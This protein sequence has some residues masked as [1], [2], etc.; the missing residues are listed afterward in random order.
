M[1][2]KNYSQVWSPPTASGLKT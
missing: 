2:P 1:N